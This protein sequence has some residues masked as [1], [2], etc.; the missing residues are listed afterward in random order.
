MAEDCL[1]ESASQIL[2]GGSKVVPYQVG[3]LE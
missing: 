3:M 1:N 2:G